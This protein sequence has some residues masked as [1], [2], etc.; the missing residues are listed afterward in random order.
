MMDVQAAVFPGTFTHTH[1]HFFNLSISRFIRVFA[2]QKEGE[3]NRGQEVS[4]FF[5]TVGSASVQ[6]DCQ[7][8]GSDPGSVRYRGTLLQGAG[9]MTEGSCQKLAET[10]T[11]TG[12]CH[13]ERLHQGRGWG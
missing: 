1:T 11:P 2:L 8:H 6:P 9:L 4:P 13:L 5:P 10:W 12:R 3:F 7:T